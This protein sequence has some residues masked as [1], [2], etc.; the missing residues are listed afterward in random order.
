MN[1]DTATCTQCSGWE[2]CSTKLI[3]LSHPS[4]DQWECKALVFPVA[5]W[6]RQSHPA[7]SE[8][9]TSQWLHTDRQTDTLVMWLVGEVTVLSHD[10][11]LFF[12]LLDLCRCFFQRSSK[13]AQ[14][15]KNA[16]YLWMWARRWRSLAG[17]RRFADKDISSVQCASST[18]LRMTRAFKTHS[19]TLKNIIFCSDKWI[20]K[21][22]PCMKSGLSCNVGLHQDHVIRLQI[23]KVT[24]INP[25]LHL[26]KIV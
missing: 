24:I 9:L 4:A 14:T 2:D 7:G 11:R 19:H 22:R 16:V 13:E 1:T 12:P 17:S 26:K 21:Q 3:P 10:P 25:T 20:K 18:S 5:L 15:A 8:G 6:A 23:K